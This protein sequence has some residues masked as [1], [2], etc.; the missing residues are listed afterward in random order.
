MEPLVLLDAGEQLVDADDVVHVPGER[1]AE[2]G[3]HADRVLVHVGLHVL[4]ADRVLVLRERDDPRLHVEVAA[5]L[6]PDDVHV[7]A[8]DQVRPVHGPARRLTALSPVPLQRQGAQHDR[9]G[10]ALRARP[11][12]LPGRVEEI[13]QH[14]NAALLDLGG[15]GVLGV[16]DEVPVEVLRDDP[17]RLGLH[18]GGH[19]GREV[20]LRIA[21]QGQLLPD[22][23]HRVQPRHAA[24]G[25]LVLGHLLGEEA[26]A[27]T[28]GQGVC[29]RCLLGHAPIKSGH[30]RWRITR[31]G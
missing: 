12:G 29:A 8:E 2:H 9:L 21:V 3:G 23:A 31:T 22:Q 5:E 15:A 28:A 14:A 4:G 10:G 16:I 7:A 18:P 17:L 6:L 20:V 27:V 24:R 25:K 19:E 30:A 13:G 26:V 1:G 11:G